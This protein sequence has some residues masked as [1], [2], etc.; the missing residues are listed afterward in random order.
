MVCEHEDVGPGFI[1]LFGESMGH[2]QLVKVGDRLV[3]VAFSTLLS[4]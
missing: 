2:H 4:T 1:M 3:V